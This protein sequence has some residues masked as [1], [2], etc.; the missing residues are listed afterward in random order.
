M[1]SVIIPIYNAQKY[2]ERTVQSVFNQTYTD[3]ELILVDD[4]SSD[5][6]YDICKSFASA[7]KNIYA[8]HKENGGQAD[9]RNYGLEKSS[10][11]YIYFMDNDDA[12][13]PDALDILHSN[14]IESN[15]D[16]SAASYTIENK[17][18]R[19]HTNETLILSNDKA[20]SMLL[21]RDM[22]IYIWTK[23][24]R[25]SFLD[26]NEIRFETGRSEEDFMFNFKAFE[27]VSKVIL[28]D[29][30]IYIYTERD[31]STCRTFPI[32]QLRKHLDD[33]IYRTSTIEN[34]VSRRYPQYINLAKDQTLLYYFKAMCTIVNSSDTNAPEIRKLTE[35]I[36][37]YFKKNKY[38]VIK[39]HRN[40][41]MT[42]LGAWTLILMPLSLYL[43]YKMKEN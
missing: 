36:F 11:E 16:I 29:S 42:L 12:L 2:L 25:R 43:R 10:G 19:E 37:A 17:K 38:Q 18:S 33:I 30:P 1:I 27:K 22:D 35:I 20:M 15:A 32:K 8:Y 31:N 5:N 39:Y 24:Y 23:L 14:I 7:Y 26:D 3:Y 41:G 28:Q 4:G 9:A 13:M 21:S 6:S 34:M 40:Y